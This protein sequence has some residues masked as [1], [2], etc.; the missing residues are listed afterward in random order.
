[1]VPIDFTRSDFGE[2]EGRAEEEEEEQ[3]GNIQTVLAR[4]QSGF[5]AEI[6]FAGDSSKM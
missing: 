1:M 2:K 3:S 6:I 4:R 5:H